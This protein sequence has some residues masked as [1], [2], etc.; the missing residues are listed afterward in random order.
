MSRFRWVAAFLVLAGVSIPCAAVRADDA[1]IG[2]AREEADGTLILRLRA[3]AE[4]GRALGEAELRYAP[5]DPDYGHVHRHLGAIPPGGEVSV[6]P[7]PRTWTLRPAI[8]PSPDRLP[9]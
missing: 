5:G 3:E 9:K 4:D 8:P 1:S 2:S 7:F 6:R